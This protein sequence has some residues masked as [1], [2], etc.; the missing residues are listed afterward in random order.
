M[1][2]AILSSGFLPV[3]DGVTVTVLYRLQRLSQ[4][5][6]QV[7]L[8]C[9]DYQPLESIYPHWNAYTGEFLPGVRIISLDSTPFMDVDFERN[10]SRQSYAQ[11]VQALDR[12]QPDVIHVDEPDR[13]FL[14]FGKIPAIDYAKAHRIPCT[15]FFHTNFLEY[16]DDY[17]ALP[18]PL[19]K[20]AKAA[21]KRF[22]TQRVFNAY[23]TTLVGSPVT[24]KKLL[25]I[26]IRNAVCEDLLG[27]D[28]EKFSPELRQDRF[29]ETHYGLRGV[30]D[31]V[32]LIFVGRLTPDKGWK[33]TLK[34]IPH[35]LQ[36]IDPAKISLIVVG[37]GELRSAIT[38][39]LGTHCDLHLLGRVLPSEIP[40]LLANS[41]IH[42]TASEKETKGLTLLE[43]FAAGIPVVAPQAGGVTDSIQPGWNGLL[44]QPGNI[45]DFVT[46]LHR[47]IEDAPLRNILGQQGRNGVQ[48]H[49]WDAAIDRLISF[50]EQAINRRQQ[51]DGT[52]DLSKTR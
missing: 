20:L 43:A 19:L 2:I 39:T 35:L 42:V 14:G 24:Y 38:T 6:H 17:I 12:F 33:F 26:G 7:L 18:S 49:G 46:Q 28:L 8:F 16:M 9:P 4:L 11:V 10:V 27:V 48:A 32:K 3:V 22:I 52:T 21:C 44:Y 36:Q 47:L 34:A 23:D 5:G 1:K 30:S 51:D 31:R 45:S 13:L 40:A 25:N 29:F 41:D 50:W 15:S 37:D